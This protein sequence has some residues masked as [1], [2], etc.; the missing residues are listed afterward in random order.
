MF[1]VFQEFHLE[2]FTA[3]CI[4]AITCLVFI[5]RYF[6]HKSKCFELM[7]QRLVHLET[8]NSQGKETHTEIFKRLNAIDIHS[9]NIEGKLDILLNKKS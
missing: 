3:I 5:V 4:P 1:E 9:A 7:K 2:V 8:E 6:W